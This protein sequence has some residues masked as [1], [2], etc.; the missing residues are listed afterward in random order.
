MGQS[1]ETP[2]SSKKRGGGKPRPGFQWPLIKPAL[3]SPV[4]ARPQ[5]QWRSFFSKRSLS[6][7]Y[8]P[9]HLLSCTS[10]KKMSSF[11]RGVSPLLPVS[12][13]PR[14]GS[15]RDC[16]HPQSQIL[17]LHSLPDCSLPQPSSN[18]QVGSE[19]GGWATEQRNQGGPCPRPGTP[20]AASDQPGNKR[21]SGT[22]ECPGLGLR[23]LSQGEQPEDAREVGIAPAQQTDLH[24][25]GLSGRGRQQPPRIGLRYFI[26]SFRKTCQ[27]QLCLTAMCSFFLPFF[28]NKRGSEARL[29]SSPLHPPLPKRAKWIREGERK[30]KKE[31]THQSPR[32]CQ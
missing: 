1:E 12:L 11:L 29:F 30:K 26:S 17:Q 18:L 25:T 21:G 15:C 8:S 4:K 7:S 2:V 19:V 9:L 16:Q 31:P 23:P 10:L 24:A 3:Q 6:I 27:K 32:G 20:S 13:R 14:L 5:S 22:R 28:H